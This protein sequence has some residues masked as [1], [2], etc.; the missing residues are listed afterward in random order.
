MSGFFFFGPFYKRV[1]RGAFS[2]T[3]TCRTILPL[4]FG[5]DFQ[6]IHVYPSSWARLE[7]V[8]WSSSRRSF[9][10]MLWR[11][12]PKHS[13]DNRRQ[14]VTVFRAKMRAVIRFNSRRNWFIARPWRG[15]TTALLLFF[16][17]HLSDLR[18]RSHH[19]TVSVKPFFWRQELPRERNFPRFDWPPN[20]CV[21]FWR[22]E[23]KLSQTSQNG[24][25]RRCHPPFFSFH[26]PLHTHT[27][28]H[29]H[30]GACT[31]VHAHVFKH[32]AHVFIHNCSLALICFFVTF[33]PKIDLFNCTM[34]LCNWPLH[35]S[36]SDNHG[37][38]LLAVCAKKKAY[39]H[40]YAH[41]SILQSSYFT[42]SVRS[43]W[44]LKA[45]RLDLL[46]VGSEV[47]LHIFY[48]DC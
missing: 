22:L 1:A 6:C 46:G 2:L 15:E 43:K 25:M 16:V 40:T 17:V 18:V 28:T 9:A 19:F 4:S 10:K 29:K 27:H 20:A 48:K 11:T 5:G 39:T 42:T 41:A 35:P 26:Y 7:F 21:G 34:V 45:L 44:N 30:M 8:Q 32:N 3:L 24:S 47:Y 38:W 13:R 33:F 31:C 12:S 23:P 37:H 36:T 14:Q